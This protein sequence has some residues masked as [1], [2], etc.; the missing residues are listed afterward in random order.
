VEQPGLRRFLDRIAEPAIQLSKGNKSLTILANGGSI[1][2]KDISLS[3]E[4]DRP[5][6]ALTGTGR[7][8]DEMA[9]QP[10]QPALVMSV[11]AEDKKALR[12]A[13]Q[14]AIQN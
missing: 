12:E 13:I 2:R 4:N 8:A 1:S 6:I 14:M 10:N 5:V 11:Q 9:N 3:L 7:L